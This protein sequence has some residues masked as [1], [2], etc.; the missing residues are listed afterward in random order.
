MRATVTVTVATA[1]SRRTSAVPSGIAGTTAANAA[2]API[3]RK[4]VVMTDAMIDATSA[5]G[6]ARPDA[7]RA[8]RRAWESLS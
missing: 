1:C 4:T 6:A 8:R 5:E 3:G 2:S 7:V